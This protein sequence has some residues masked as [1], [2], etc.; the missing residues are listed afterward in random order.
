MTVDTKVTTR[1]ISLCLQ[2]LLLIKCHMCL[3]F[4]NIVSG[5]NLDM[6]W[7]GSSPLEIPKKNIRP[8]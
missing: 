6:A 1:N 4:I 2:H 3:S 5:M 7:V 8:S